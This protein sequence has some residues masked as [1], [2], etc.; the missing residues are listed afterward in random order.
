VNPLTDQN[1]RTIPRTAEALSFVLAIAVVI[2]IAVYSYFDWEELRRSNHDVEQT[3]LI[4]DRADGILS[5]LK[6]AETGQRGFLLTGKR[7]YL[8]PYNRALSVIPTR[9]DELTEAVSGQRRQLDKVSALRPLVDDKLAES[10]LTIELRQTKGPEAALEVVLSDQGI[11]LMEQ[12]R[13]YCAEIKTAEYERLRERSAV[14][15]SSA[16]RTRL[17]STLGSLLLLIL[18]GVAA[19][20]VNRGTSRREE[21][22]R[23]VQEK[24]R[25]SRRAG[26]LLS[27]TL[28]S[29][30]DAVITTDASGKITFMNE[31]AQKLTGWRQAEAAGAY[32]DDVFRIINEDARKP[33]E[34]PVARALRDGAVAGLANHTILIAKNGTE[35]AIDDSAAPIWD[36]DRKMVGVVLVFRGVAERREAEKALERSRREAEEARDLLQTTLASIGDAVIATDAE[37]R[38]TFMNP[39][40]ERLTGWKRGDAARLPVNQVFA[41]LH[42]DTLQRVD[43]P[44]ERSLREGAATGLQSRSVL[45]TKEGGTIAI[46]DSAA[47]IRSRNGGVIGGVI[48]FRDIT[49]RRQAE[50]ALEESEQRFRSTFANAPIGMVITDIDAH[51]LQIN[52]A[53]SDITGYTA[54]ELSRISFLSLTHPEEMANNRRL[55]EQLR[56]G[57]VPSYVLEKRIVRQNKE[58]LWVRSSVTLL[59]DEISGTI[60]VISLLEDIS[61]RKQAEIALA[62]QTK[63]AALGADVG[64]ALTRI[65]QLPAALQHCTAAVVN[66]LQMALVR[67]WTIDQS[68]GFLELQA[69]AGIDGAPAGAGA[70]IP[71]G[72]GKIGV[73]ARERRPYMTNQIIGDPMVAD[74]KWAAEHGMV[75]FAGYPLVVENQLVGVMGM[76]SRQPVPPDT[77]DALDSAVNSIAMAIE[78]ARVQEQRQELLAREREARE[79]LERSARDLSRSNE[80][81]RRFADAASHDLRSPL[82]TVNGMAG[83][84]KKRYRDRLDP[85]A[86]K[87]LGMIAGGIARMDTLIS[88]LLA[89]SKVSDVQMRPEKISLDD[90]VKGALVNLGAAIE[91]SG[92]MITADPLPPVTAHQSLVAQVFQNLISNAIKYRNEQRIEIHIGVQRLASECVVSVKDNGIGIDQQHLTEVFDAFKRLHGNE[93]PGSGIGLATCKRIIDRYGGQIWVEST[94]GEGSTFFFTLPLA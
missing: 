40:A 5:A 21:L 7:Q 39:I 92:A 79:Q 50:R 14:A 27:V 82:R 85:E 76:F 1:V 78:R 11:Q 74:Q 83:L 90:T 80:D 3:R 37:A 67:V 12:I 33:A 54:E 62:R 59:L 88:D 70:R 38:V 22:I 63:L 91:E 44:L 65:E 23:I 10:K 87:L 18:F 49:A 42:E 13:E 75:A 56:N 84:L 71:I 51:V 20:L 86:D 69:T 73:I 57:D 60:Q 30:G 25:E 26:D 29:I 81:L 72:I 55:F 77:L 94:P 19:V 47:P 8:E 2:S 93:Y 41:V 15:Q 48:V 6:D 46:D 9:M 64:G 28:A 53:A 43:N 52:Q 4:V 32:L 89:F 17:V 61:V 34:S 16:N 66:H 58:G 31:L 68:G 24:E 35:V 36:R 45:R